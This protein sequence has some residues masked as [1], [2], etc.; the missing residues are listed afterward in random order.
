MLKRSKMKRIT[1]VV[2]VSFACSSILSVFGSPQATASTDGQ[3]FTKTADHIVISKFN[4]AG[5]RPSFSSGTAVKNKNLYKYDFVE[6]YNP[7][8]Q[9]V[10]L[11]GWKIQYTPK[12]SGTW[13]SSVTTNIY[14][15]IQP[16]GYFLVQ[17]DFDKNPSGIQDLTSP[18]YGAELPTPD[19]VA[20]AETGIFK[21]DKD[22]GKI[23][24]IGNNNSSKD[25]VVYGDSTPTSAP[26]MKVYNYF[27][28]KA[29]NPVDPTGTALSA[30][31]ADGTPNTNENNYGNGYFTGNSLNDFDIGGG[32]SILTQYQT[33]PANVHNSLSS[34]HPL[35]IYA[36]AD[37]LYSSVAMSTNTT[38][39]ALKNKVALQLPF[40][41]E[42]KNDFDESY[43]IV[44]NLPQ[45][46]AYSVVP[47]RVNH[48]LEVWI[49]GTANNPITS[50]Q[51]FTVQI[52]AAGVT[53][54]EQTDSDPVN[55]TI[56]AALPKINASLISSDVQMTTGTA[57]DPKHASFRLSV[58]NVNGVSLK[59]SLVSS[60]YSLVPALPQGLTLSATVNDS[61]DQITFSVSGTS[62]V[63]VTQDI[64]YSITLSNAVMSSST[65][66]G[67][68]IQDANPVGITIRKMD[69]KADLARKN[70]LIAAIKASN[71]FF[72]DPVMKAAKYAT[73]ANTSFDFF[74]GNP[75][76][77]FGD[78]NTSLLP[79][80]DAWKQMDLKT[81]VQGDAYLQNIGTFE[82]ASGQ[83]KF[84]LNDY[85]SSAT[86][87]FYWDL[88]RMLPSLFLERDNG[89]A[90]EKSM[91]DADMTDIVNIFLD[92]YRGTLVSLSGNANLL[93]KELT[94][95]NVDGFTKTLLDKMAAVTRVNQLNSAVPV[96]PQTQTRKFI[97]GSKYSLLTPE[98]RY[99][100]E[101]SW[102][103][104][105]ASIDSFAKSKNPGYFKIKDVVYRVN[106]GNA[107]RGSMRF[108]VLIEGN[109]TGQDDDILLDVKEEFLPN[110]LA[111]PEANRSEYDS[112][113]GTDHGRRT[114]DN[115]K[116]L[117]M[118]TESYAGSM[119]MGSRSFLV[120]SIAVSKGD[121]TDIKT[122]FASKA[123]L[124][125]YVKYASQAYAL[126]H[127]RSTS[128]FAGKFVNTMDDSTW[129]SF[130]QELLE[131]SA[132]YYIQSKSDYALMQ[133][134][135]GD[136]S[137]LDVSHLSGIEVTGSNGT[138]SLSPAFVNLTPYD[139]YSNA[140]PIRSYKVNVPFDTESVSVRATAADS[141]AK[142]SLNGTTVVGVGEQSF[143]LQVGDNPIYVSVTAQDESIMNYTLT[144]TRAAPPSSNAD[145]KSLI[146]SGGEIS[147]S[148][149][150]DTTAYT[151]KVPSSV[152]NTTVTVSVY[153]DVYSTVMTNVYNGEGTLVLGPVSLKNN[154]PSVDLP[155]SE[156]SNSIKVLVTA[157]DGTVKTYTVNVIR[158]TAVTVGSDGV[159]PITDVPVQISV[160]EDATNAK[161][162]VTTITA[163]ANKE[164]TL[165]QIQVLSSTSL[166]NVG[167][168]IPEGTKITATSSWDGTI[169]L[170]TI[171]SNSSVSIPNASVS[172]VVEVGAPDVTLT[173]DKA[174]RLLLPGQGGKAAGYLRSGVFTPI[175]GKISEDSQMA[176]NLEIAAGGEAAITVGSDLV[177][178]TKHFTMFVSY[179]AISP[180]TGNGSSGAAGSSNSGTISA[181][182]G[183][184]LTLNGA[185]IDVPAGAMTGIIQVTVDKVS[186][187]SGIPIDSDLQL[188]SEVYEI[189]KD[190]DGE[191]SKPVIIT[192]PFDKTKAD[193]K[194]SDVAVYY[195]NEQTHAWVKLTDPKLDLEMGKA[196]G[197]V[198]HFSKFAVLA[199]NKMKT[200]P[201]PSVN[202]QGFS[203]LKGHWA[204]AGVLEL[205][206]QG[207]LNGYSDG[208]FKPN[209][210]I[211][212]AEFVTIVVKAFH[213]NEKK[214]K[215]FADTDTHWAKMAIGTAAALD[216]VSGYNDSTFGPDDFITREQMAAIIVRAA[217]ITSTDKNTR[218]TDN[219][220][221][222]DWARASL[223]AATEKGLLNGY[224]DGTVKPKEKTTR[225]EA[226]VVILR[227]LQ[228]K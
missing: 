210:N 173:F 69:S 191:F 95:N 151:V 184:T 144:V 104:Y 146:L 119:A 84:D 39:D 145:L 114:A 90:A 208:T 206:K 72:S 74:R 49:T 179:T 131:L 94:T 215:S 148:F 172:G 225:A 53:S 22:T 221:I 27:V 160:P 20:T 140:F 189:K 158:T 142:V 186:G 217:R 205:V 106:Q 226:A 127:A 126:A 44:S 62:S 110:L 17:E 25:L 133:P 61:K 79:V 190:K 177:I 203:D 181:T 85:D 89:T 175:T 83:V 164:A 71:A 70:E 168:A 122:A 143:K 38:V 24:L 33:N 40:L 42:L 34:R 138:V 47:D 51:S 219:T 116:S 218:F 32:T 202:E 163:G 123:D 88:L 77:F 193:L 180:S 129:N 113:Y 214:G 150:K 149:T 185:S 137:L 31:S 103:T 18:L 183:G 50:N 139:G 30:S 109:S 213:L 97:A 101:S 66:N 182:N 224:Q 159:I 4:P 169:Q 147:P 187:T 125:N 128:A 161:L 120:R 9:S 37:P 1:S 55:F 121:Y 96:D 107:S 80:P 48:R 73:Q 75:A 105:L 124:A 78:L 100:F 65:V 14:G 46:L 154:E 170:P 155:L 13:Q 220:E 196:S 228:Q 197:A 10:D 41:T 223:A 87:P 56:A 52:K 118:N 16:H 153:D 2:L 68:I 99:Q 21:M 102:N 199:S 23:E 157:Q 165:P 171:K 58:P 7:T 136:G 45:G 11:T 209:A 204:E 35:K 198:T 26:A 91:T 166:G 200:A 156:G 111:N 222:S 178:W 57:I 227:V 130:K 174:V 64:S 132:T 28:R 194:S 67:Q 54:G 19:V 176:A 211:T 207:I 134:I 36:K 192:L 8:G 141:K 59:D 43:V 92:E 117:M 212:R 195:L 6:L 162:T 3:A 152:V 60:S 93:T 108:N 5:N 167:M 115:Y 12:V 98:Q 81:I 29:V 76:V 86:A 135:M 112:V 216:I 82:N 63:P 201:Q 188:I 15:T